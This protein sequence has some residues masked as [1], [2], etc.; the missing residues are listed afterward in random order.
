MQAAAAAQPAAAGSPLASERDRLRGKWIAQMDRFL[1]GSTADSLREAD[2]AVVG[3]F[4][5]GGQRAAEPTHQQ[6]KRVKS[7]CSPVC[8]TSL[9][10]DIAVRYASYLASD[11]LLNLALTSK[12]YGAPVGMRRGF[13]SLSEEV[14]RLKYEAATTSEKGGVPRREGRPLWLKLLHRLELLKVPLWFDHLL[15]SAMRTYQV[16]YVGGDL[17]RVT[18]GVIH[19]SRLGSDFNCTAISSFVMSEG[20]HYA[21]F[22][23]NG[24][25]HDD[26]DLAFRIGI[27]RPVDV[28]G[29]NGERRRNYWPF[30]SSGR[31]D[32]STICC[33]YDIID[34]TCDYLESGSDGLDYMDWDG[35]DSSEGERDVAIGLLLDLDNGTLAVFKNGRRLGVMKDG[36]AGDFCWMA[37]LRDWEGTCRIAIERGD[38][39]E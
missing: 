36:L 18:F 19:T 30:T 33:V 12:L 35:M 26:P 17:S 32:G 16:K 20:K 38:L 6:R 8:L 31:R 22:H 39:P 10:A 3:L 1:D 34:G 2:S 28:A 4:G 9:S 7:D 24:I 21:V 5:G 15:G 11:D 13:W 27:V 23:M 29:W 14:A 25:G 37:N